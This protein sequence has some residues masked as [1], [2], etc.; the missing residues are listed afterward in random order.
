MKTNKEIAEM[1][2]MD[3]QQAMDN[4]DFDG[5]LAAY[6]LVESESFDWD[7]VSDDLFNDW[8][9]LTDEGNILIGE[10]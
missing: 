4:R 6:D 2:I 10:C 9:K 1:A 3:L 5:I 8:D 7:D